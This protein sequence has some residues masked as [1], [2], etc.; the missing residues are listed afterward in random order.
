LSV[1]DLSVGQQGLIVSVDVE[2]SQIARFACM[3]LRRGALLEVEGKAPMGSPIRIRV[4]RSFLALRKQDA[5]QIHVQA[6]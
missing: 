2:G 6:Q 5:Q 3:G 4:G 1:A